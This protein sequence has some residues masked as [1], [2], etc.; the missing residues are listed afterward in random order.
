MSVNKNK[1]INWRQEANLDEL[2]KSS[3][4]D[5]EPFPDAEFKNGI[6][7]S[8]PAFVLM[9]NFKSRQAIREGSLV[10]LTKS[11]KRRIVKILTTPEIIFVI[12]DGGLLDAELDGSPNRVK[13]SSY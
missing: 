11:G 10:A 13:I 2:E 7:L 8:A 6:S 3:I 9:N 12:T 4:L 1:S 5:I